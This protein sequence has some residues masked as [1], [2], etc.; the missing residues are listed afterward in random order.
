[1]LASSSGHSQILSCSHGEKSGEGLGSLL[2]H[3]LE[4]VDTVSM[5]RVHVTYWPSPPFPVR[6]VVLIPGLLPIFL[7][8]CKIKSGSGLG[9]RLS[10]WF[11]KLSSGKS[12]SFDLLYTRVVEGLICIHTNAFPYWS[13]FQRFVEAF[14]GFVYAFRLRLW[15]SHSTVWE[16]VFWT[17]L[18]LLKRHAPHLAVPEK[19]IPYISSQMYFHLLIILKV[20]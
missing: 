11:K 19:Y 16:Y 7:Q 14:W 15:Y 3:R 8:D 6:D 12:Y 9:T 10:P 4:V 5:N 2:H 18:S 13:V 20:L 17:T 1:M